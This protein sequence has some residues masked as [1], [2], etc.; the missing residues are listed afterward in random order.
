M[1]FTD[2]FI[3]R[4]VVAIVV[5]LLILLAGYQAMRT[6]NVPQYPKTDISII[7]VTTT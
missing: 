2:L 4:P 1:K 7:T 5:N 3:K 6:L